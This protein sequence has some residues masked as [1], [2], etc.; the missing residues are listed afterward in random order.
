MVR[1]SGILAAVAAG[2]LLA[3]CAT[4]PT[5]PEERA[6]VEAM[7]DP[8]EPAN[9]TIFDINMYLDEAVMEPVVEAY[10]DTF[11]DWFRQAVHNMLVNIEEPYVAGNDLL[12]GNIRAAADSLGRF[13]IN[14]TFGFLGTRDAVADSGGPRSHQTDIGVTLAVW[15]FDEGPY[16]MLPILGPSNLR[17]G[18]GKVADYWAHPTGAVLSSYGLDAVN[19]AQTG[20]EVIDT[21]TQFIDPIREIRRTSLDQY[22]AIRSLY[23]Q[24]RD[25]SIANARKGQPPAQQ[26]PSQQDAGAAATAQPI[27]AATP[28]DTGAGAPDLKAKPGAVEFIDKK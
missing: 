8:L 6:E 13:M 5:D 21:R 27:P 11:P 10:R 19:Y 7:N 18:V 24:N 23:R 9:R 20:S 4:L 3:A 2:A 16:L 22:A 15:G 28:A 17:D 1:R 26:A 25:S 14:S 12:Q